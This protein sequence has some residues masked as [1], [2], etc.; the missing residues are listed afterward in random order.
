MSAG[1]QANILHALPNEIRH[2]AGKLRWGFL[3]EN[4]EE[5]SERREG[6]DGEKGSE[7]GQ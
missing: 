1:D 6:A 4:L 7:I 3:G 5:K 2:R